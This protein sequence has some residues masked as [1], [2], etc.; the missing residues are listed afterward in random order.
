MPLVEKRYAEALLDLAG[1]DTEKYKDDLNQF[2]A[3]YN[4]DKEFSSFLLDPRIKVDKKQLVINNVFKGKIDNNILN[5]IL[6]LLA[7]QRV[8][9]APQIYLQFVRIAQER[10]NVLE[11]KIISAAPL[12]D[13][14]VEAIKEKF[15]KKFNA[16]AVKDIVTVD[17]S[18][19]GGVKVIVGDK[20]YDGSIKGRIDSLKELVSK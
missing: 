20:V 7:K 10:A 13:K 2:I 19:I 8:D 5:F 17:E 15:K 6:L 3:I 12:E 16:S 9:I 1:S 14:Q 4:S 18:L 11:V